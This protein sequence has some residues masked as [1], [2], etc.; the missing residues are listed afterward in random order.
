MNRSP[1]A[2]AASAPHTPRPGA[3]ARTTAVMGLVGLVGLLHLGGCAVVHGVPEQAR[4]V[5]DAGTDW[6]RQATGVR[7]AEY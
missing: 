4:G 2:N 3:L 6:Y 1:A 5:A 7:D